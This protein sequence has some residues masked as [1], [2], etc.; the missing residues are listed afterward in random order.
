MRLQ[1]SIIPFL[2][3]V[4]DIQIAFSVRVSRMY[5]KC[6]ALVPKYTSWMDQFLI[7]LDWSKPKM[8]W[9]LNIFEI[10]IYKIQLFREKKKKKNDLSELRSARRWWVFLLELLTEKR[11]ITASFKSLPEL[12]WMKFPNM[13]TVIFFPA[14]EKDLLILSTASGLRSKLVYPQSQTRAAVFCS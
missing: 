12:M 14:N 13:Q 8:P 9:F 6:T 10:L 3:K 4:T 1:I 11:G 7:C 5:L 2:L